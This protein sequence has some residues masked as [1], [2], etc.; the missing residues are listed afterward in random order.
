MSDV[1]RYR[2]EVTPRPKEVGGGW[3]LQLFEDDEEMG[4]GIFEGNDEGYQ[5]ALDQGED[6]V[7]G[8]DEESF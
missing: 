6:W 1:H 7:W 2:Y 8:K 3:K 5:A 4:G